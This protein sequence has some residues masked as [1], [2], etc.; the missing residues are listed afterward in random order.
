MQKTITFFPLPSAS[1]FSKTWFSKE[2]I[3][4]SLEVWLAAIH[5]AADDDDDDAFPL[6]MHCVT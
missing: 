2:P 1:V 5:N 6:T 3:F 4:P